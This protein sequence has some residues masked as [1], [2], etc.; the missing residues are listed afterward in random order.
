[1]A[2]GSK[3]V[4]RRYLLHLTA[5]RNFLS[6][7]EGKPCLSCAVD[8]LLFREDFQGFNIEY[9]I[10]GVSL[11]E[12]GVDSCSRKNEEDESAE[13]LSDRGLALFE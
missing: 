2:I 5:T 12:A 7:L 11:A 9:N 4:T 10:M 6:T 3:S 8:N 1:M 13:L